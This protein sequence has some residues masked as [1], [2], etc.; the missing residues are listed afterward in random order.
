[1][2]KVLSALVLLLSIL[3]AQAQEKKLFNGFDGGMMVHT[4]Y[5]S[6]SIG[7]DRI[8]A[9]GLPLGIGGVIRLHVGNHFRVGSE[10]YVSTLDQRGNGSYVKYGWGGILADACVV[11]GKVMPYAGLTVGGGSA[12]TLLMEETPKTAWAPID[13]TIYHKQGFLALC[14]FAGCDFIVSDVMHLT[15]KADWLNCL[16]RNVSAPSGPRIYFGFLFYH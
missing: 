16:G 13:G 6:G 4:G 12:T 8:P 3:P 10:G 2:K 7:P 14:P 15:L 5:L 1:M 9:K 11:L